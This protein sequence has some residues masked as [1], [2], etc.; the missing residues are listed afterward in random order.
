MFNFPKKSILRHLEA[1][2]GRSEENKKVLEL[3]FTP[4]N[5]PDEYFRSILRPPK[6]GRNIQFSKK[7]QKRFKIFEQ[8][9]KISKQFRDQ[10][11][12]VR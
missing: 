5:T 1:F 7:F 3:N 4:G 10:S 2:F 6:V 12:M 9:S 11:G 8:I